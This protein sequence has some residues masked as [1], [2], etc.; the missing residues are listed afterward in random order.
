MTV[1]LGI[2]GLLCILIAWIPETVET[3]KAKKCRL[4]MQFV[5]IYVSGA[6]LLTIYSVQVWDLVFIVLNVGATVMGAI[7]LYYKLKFR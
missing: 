2:I 7:N 1:L 6:A 4:N 5:E 3:I